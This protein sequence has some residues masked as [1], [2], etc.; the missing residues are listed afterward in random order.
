MKLK[1]PSTRHPKKATLEQKLSQLK[2]STLQKPKNKRFNKAFPFHLK[3]LLEFGHSSFR[4]SPLKTTV[5]VVSCVLFLV[6]CFFV[7]NDLPSPTKLKGQS[8]PV[9]T[10]IMDRNGI[11]LY[12]IYADR[13]RTPIKIDELPP[14][15][16]N[17]AIAIED[18][19]F[20]RHLGFSIEGMTR[21]VKNILL[22][23]KLQGGSTI[24]Q[25][26]VKTA[27][28]TPERT[29]KRK[30][31]EAILTVATEVIYSK[32]DILEM[33]LN[34]IPYGGTSWGIEAAAKTYFNKSAKNLSLA[35]AALI[36]GLPAAPSR[37]SP[38]GVNPDLA[39][40]RQHEVLRRMSE[41]GYITPAEAEAAKAEKLNF[42]TDSI[43]IRAPHFALYV[44]DLLTEK[45]GQQTVERGGLRVITS[46][47]INLQEVAEASLS[48]EI[49]TLEKYKVSN[50]AA[51]ITHPNTGEI[52]AMIGSKNYFSS[53][54]DGQVNVTLRHRQ[55]GSSIKPVNYAIAFENRI[56]TPGTTLLD[57][58]TCFE[59]LGQPLY[60]PKNY[61]NSFHGPVQMRFALGNSYNIPAVK[62]LAMNSLES[63]I[64][65]A[66]AMGI[67]SFTNPQN[68]GLSL[69]LGGGEV[70]MVEMATAFGVL[71]NQGVKVDLH[72]ILKV[73]DWQ[74]NIL[75]EYDASLAKSAVDQLN[76]SPEFQSPGSQIKVKPA[77]FQQILENS[78]PNSTSIP[79]IE[80][81]LHRAPAYLISH[82]LLDNNARMAAFGS[83]SQLIIPKQVVSVKTGT[84]NN[85]RD[86]WTIGYTPNYLV[87]VW[88]GNNDSSPMNP[89]LVSGI[90]GAAPIFHDIMTYTLR[91]QQPLWPEKPDDV[92][93]REICT[94]SGQVSSP[95]HP[96][97][98]RNEFF[99]EGTEPGQ[100]DSSRRDVWIKNDTN[101]Q[102][103]SGDS[104]NVR[105]ESHTV[106]SDPFTKD[107]CTDCAKPL[108]PEGKPN[109]SAQVIKL[110]FILESDPLHP[111]NNQPQ[112]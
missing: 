32:N 49:K 57:V 70:R 95:E 47:D 105:S 62:V 27:L 64:A 103:A 88:V 22:H 109:E 98:T 106:L 85:L 80:R 93:S 48:A 69:T 17:A 3:S 36:A 96:C 7:L 110:P 9:S 86:N 71:A 77:S 34:H 56:L 104:D 44:K 112:E 38:F 46:L 75:E 91:D 99:W 61:D 60:C 51:L 2:H 53:D 78:D 89:Y 66:R 41:D 35:E 1:S 74:G 67:T 55:P 42:A 68:Y 12:E 79:V 15:V 73:T 31:R 97:S 54:I 111:D 101:V 28:L 76:H 50:G 19:N 14:Y 94:V 72:P 107:Y 18:K 16:K 4:R 83:N 84:T 81:I 87:A 59:S 10:T 11:V 6:S 33:Y 90:T 100:F 63:F 45:Y 39:I 65:S 29:L 25:Q 20:Y 30:I 92:I 43:T 24:T 26:L 23:D 82:I 108:N 21:A 102:A 37:F 40:A 13:N 8:Y 52:L 5:F 58:P